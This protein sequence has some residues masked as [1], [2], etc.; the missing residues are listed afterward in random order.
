MGEGFARADGSVGQDSVIPIVHTLAGALGGERLQAETRPLA[1]A[2]T[3]RLR[4][5]YRR[6][7][8]R[9][10]AMRDPSALTT[11]IATLAH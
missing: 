2:H 10:R 8:P 1:Q 11:R 3:D 9:S 4:P 6:A 5:N 7:Q